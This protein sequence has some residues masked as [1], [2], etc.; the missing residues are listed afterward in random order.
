MRGPRNTQGLYDLLER[1]PS[2]IEMVEVG[3]YAGESAKIF[4]SSGK[5]DCL[6]AVDIW[7]DDLGAYERL[8]RGHDFKLVEKRFDE[9]TQGFNV[10]KFKMT[11]DSALPGLPIVDFA[12]IDANH[13]YDFVKS[14]ILN[15]LKILKP[16]GIIAGHDYVEQSPGVI[17]AVDEIFGKPDRVFSDK[18][19]LVD[20]KNFYK[21]S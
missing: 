12:Y 5:I 18:S 3:S 17:E 8:Q 19:W 9:E 7:S 6:Y 14:D 4:L 21:R 16:S 20:L 15:C 13:D 10:K 1:L 11:L 2:N